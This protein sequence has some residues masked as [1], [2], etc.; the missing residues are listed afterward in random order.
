MSPLWMSI[1]PLAQETRLMLSVPL[2]G[3]VLKARLAQPPAHPRAL[4]L[5][6]ESLSAWY[7]RPLHAVLAADAQA[8]Q[9][10]PERWAELLGDLPGLDISVEWVARGEVARRRDRFLAELGDFASGRSLLHFAAT[11][12]R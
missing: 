1:E 10:F 11:G 12:Q 3:T 6:L 2:A 9:S 8:V 5:L 4:S 7:R